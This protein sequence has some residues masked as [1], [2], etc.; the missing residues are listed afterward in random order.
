MCA[1]ICQRHPSLELTA[2]TARGGRRP[3]PRRALP[4]LPRAARAGGVRPGRGGGAGRRRARGLPAQ[5]GGAGGQGAARAR[6]RRWSTCRRTSASTARATSAGTSRTRRRSCSTRPC[7]GCPRR[8]ATRSATADLVAAPGCNSTA[9][10]LALLPLRGRMDDAVVDIKSG[11]S[12]R[13]ARGHRGDP[14]RVG[15]RQREPL[16]DRG[17][18]PRG[19]A[20]AG[21]A[22]RALRVRAAPAADRPGDPRQ[23]LRER[24]RAAHQ[25]RRAR[26]VRAGLRRRAVRGGDRRA[27]PHPRRARHQPR[28]RL[29]DGR[30]RPGAR[31]SARST[32]SGRAP[33]ARRSRT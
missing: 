18:P 17:P 8:T 27:A 22:R 23:L 16:Q 7:T 4:A 25:G 20:R 30:G 24:R 11:V 29:R 10:L 1:Y 13:R 2:V 15:G 21:A 28:D 33:P 31:R 12:G 6:A 3:A 19:R 32:T 14:L 5:G 26:A 9:A